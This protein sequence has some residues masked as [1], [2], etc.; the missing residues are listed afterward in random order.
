M[1]IRN[2]QPTTEYE[3]REYDGPRPSS[4]QAIRWGAH[5]IAD[6]KDCEGRCQITAIYGDRGVNITVDKTFVP[7]DTQWPNREVFESEWLGCR[8]HKAHV[9]G[10]P[11]T[12]EEI[13]KMLYD[14]DE[15]RE[16]FS[17]DFDH[18]LAGFTFRGLTFRE[19]I[20]V[21]LNLREEGILFPDSALETLAVYVEEERQAC[22]DVQGYLD[23]NPIEA[24][25]V[26]PIARLMSQ[27]GA[28]QESESETLAGSVS[29]G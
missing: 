21:L 12:T 23:S 1:N 14:L 28:E 17:Q 25:D 11:E 8:W 26:A 7:A 13:Q 2:I 5:P 20:Q 27:V 19:A 6:W 16:K 22:P 9:E 3:L 15:A 18:R 4:M 29:A 24:G 10:D